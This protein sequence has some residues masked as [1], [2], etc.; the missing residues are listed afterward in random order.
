MLAGHSMPS[1]NEYRCNA[2]GF[3][4][5]SGWGYCFY[6]EDAHGARIKCRH[7]S[8]RGYVYGVLGDA[9][10]ERVLE[11]TGFISPCV[12]L[13]CLH[14]FEADFGER[15]YSPFEGRPS[16]P[17]YRQPKAIDKRECPNCGSENVETELTMVGKLC[18]K[19]KTGIIEEI[20]TGAIS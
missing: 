15:G 2:C 9:S 19:C 12:C 5:P 11:K 13:E 10:L 1:I 4:L 17:I 6:V 20:P 16:R 18:P 7:P 8:E 3:E 14:Q